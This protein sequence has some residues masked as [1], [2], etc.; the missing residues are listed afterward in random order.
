MT[1]QRICRNA[2]RA[3]INNS[4]TLIFILAFYYTFT[5]VLAKVV[6]PAL[7]HI[8]ALTFVNVLGLPKVDTNKD[9]LKITKLALKLFV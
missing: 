9:L 5:L 3:F 1:K 2:S 8:L 6:T 7:T 4:N